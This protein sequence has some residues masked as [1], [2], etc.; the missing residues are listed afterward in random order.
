MLVL[1][2]GGKPCPTRTEWCVWLSVSEALHAPREASLAHPAVHLAGVHVCALSTC[3]RPRTYTPTG[4]RMRWRTVPGTPG[5]AAATPILSIHI[6]SCI[7]AVEWDFVAVVSINTALFWPQSAAGRASHRDTSAPA[8]RD[9]RRLGR[10]G[11]LDAVRRFEAGERGV[12][13]ADRQPP[14]GHPAHR[15]DASIS[16]P[17]SARWSRAPGRSRRGLWFRRRRRRGGQAPPRRVR[18]DRHIGRADLSQLEVPG[19]AGDHPVQPVDHPGRVLPA[20]ASMGLRTDLAADALDARLA[21]PI[22][23][24]GATAPRAEFH[25]KR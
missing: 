20:I 7:G 6:F 9:M 19:P 12:A 10:E 16:T 13:R 25:P 5:G 23:D 17:C 1:L 3:S 22:A 15:R 8:G 2:Q 4:V 14:R 21:R 18:I 24:V 11:Y